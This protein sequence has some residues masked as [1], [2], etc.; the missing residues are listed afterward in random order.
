MSRRKEEQSQDILLRKLAQTKFKK[1]HPKGTWVEAEDME[2]KEKLEELDDFNEDTRFFHESMACTSRY[3]TAR[4]C[5]RTQA[6]CKYT[7]TSP[8]PRTWAE[9]A[10]PR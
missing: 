9:R 1:E 5:R 2:L 6:R 8:M 7:Y 3:G 4:R 10:L